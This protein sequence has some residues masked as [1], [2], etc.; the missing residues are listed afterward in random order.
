MKEKF[1]LIHNSNETLKNKSCPHLQSDEVSYVLRSCLGSDPANTVKSI[2]DDISEMWKRID[3][4][5]GDP[6]KI[7][8]VIIE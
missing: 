7:A 2:D 5:Y 1:A 8:D 6:A 4:K 3:E